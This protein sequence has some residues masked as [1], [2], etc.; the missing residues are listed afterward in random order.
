VNEA[1]I[2][3]IVLSDLH[4]A[5]AQPLDPKRPL[6]KRF[7]NEDLFIDDSFARFLEEAMQEADGPIEIVFAGDTFDFDAVVALPADPSF[8]INWLEARRG[9]DASEEKSLFKMQVILQTHHVW[10]AALRRFLDA[11]NRAV[12]VIGNHDI[13]LHWPS[14]Q[15]LLREALGRTEEQ[16][17]LR[18]CEWFYLSNGD[19]LIEH[20]NQYDAYCVCSDP[21]WPFIERNGT[22]F[23]RMPFGNL[24]SKIMLNGMGLFNPNVDS[25]FIMTMRE[26]LSFFFKYVARVQPFLLFTWLW[27]ALATAIVSLREGLL[28][29]KRNPLLVE[30]RVADIARRANATPRMVRALKSIHNHPAIFN[31][32]MII[33]ELWLDRALFFIGLVWISVQGFAFLNVFVSLRVWWMLVPLILLMPLFIFYARS[34]HSDVDKAERHAL[35]AAEPLCSIAGVERMIF[36]HTHHALHRE[37]NGVEVI[38]TGS[39][40]PAFEDVQC[41]KPYGTKRFACIRP[42]KDG[43]GR[44]AHLLEWNDVGAVAAPQAVPSKR[45]R[46][47]ILQPIT[48]L[49]E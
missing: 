28:P 1:G 48:T 3:T 19:T 17:D 49:S 42:R 6:W 9:L 5:D 46:R 2:T 25:S 33:R 36:G 32:W 34:V 14:V 24:A 10:I 37:Q 30:E 22:L 38:N 44:E 13:E 4:L 12:F 7:K 39:W 43:A 29:A 20:G 31:P 26:Y 45:K 15:R 35:E 47:S 27:S 40:S 18:I 16:E 8:P 23:V 11:G 41:T 21:V